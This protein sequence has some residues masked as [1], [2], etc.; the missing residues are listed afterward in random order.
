MTTHR[1]KPDR[2][3]KSL[4]TR[5]LPLILVIWLVAMGGYVYFIV[6]AK[7]PYSGPLETIVHAHVRFQVIIDGQ[8][9]TLYYIP[10]GIGVSPALWNNHTLDGYGPTGMSPIRTELPDGVIHIE[11]VKV[12]SRISNGF[13]LKDFFN[14]WGKRIDNNCI[15]IDKVYCTGAYNIK[16]FID[17]T[18]RPETDPQWVSGPQPGAHLRGKLLF[19]ESPLIRVDITSISATTS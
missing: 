13:V 17:D 14:I 18:T 19:L 6:L 4:L 9:Q 11:L 15:E 2:D 1:E 3:K 7:T 10:A 12:D 8:N 16:T 5:L